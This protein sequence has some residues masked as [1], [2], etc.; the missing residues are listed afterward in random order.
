MEGSAA[1]H[2]ALRLPLHQRSDSTCSDG[3]I[4]RLLLP[5]D[6]RTAGADEED[7]CR[8]GTRKAEEE[9]GKGE[10]GRRKKAKELNGRAGSVEMMVMIAV[11]TVLV[12]RFYSQ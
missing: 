7:S 8:Q 10:T 4:L 5:A 9:T 6:A 11:F 1:K 12:V 2:V 3:K